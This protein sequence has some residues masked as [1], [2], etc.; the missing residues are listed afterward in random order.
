MKGCPEIT[1]RNV[2]EITQ[3]LWETNPGPREMHQRSWGKDGPLRNNLTPIPTL[4]EMATR[5]AR[6][7]EVARQYLSMHSEF[8]PELV[9]LQLLSAEVL[10]A[11]EPECTTLELAVASGLAW[12][13]YRL[14]ALRLYHLFIHLAQG[15]IRVDPEQG[16]TLGR[17]LNP[18]LNQIGVVC[19]A[20]QLF[21]GFPEEAPLLN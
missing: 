6:A 1:E 5:A 21:P 3:V 17:Y 20:A 19:F 13:D 11:I 2:E 9:D 12:S 14:P 8:F 7:H 15:V 4:A 18:V 10:L 16:T